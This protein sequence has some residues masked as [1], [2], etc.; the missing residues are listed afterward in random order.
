MAGPGYEV[1]LHSDAAV[2]DA[3]PFGLG[4]ATPFQT[5]AWLAQWYASFCAQPDH[6]P[7]IALVLDPADPRAPMTERLVMAMPLVR[8]RRHGLPLIEWADRGVTDCNLPL[9]GS[10]P[11][12]DIDAAL[13]AVSRAVR[14]YAR[15]AMRKMPRTVDGRDNPLAGEARARREEIDAFHLPL[16]AD[17]KAFEARLGA[18]KVRVLR[19]AKRILA[20]TGHEPVFRF[21]RSVAERRAVLDLIARSQSAR[22]GGTEGYLLDDP[23]YAGF[24][25]ALVAGDAVE[26]GVTRL[27]AIWLGDRPVAGLLTLVAHGR[28]VCVRLGMVDDAEIEKAGPGRLLVFEMA[29]WAAG[30]GFGVLDLS[31]GA[32]TLKTWLHCEAQPLVKVTRFANGFA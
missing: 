26:G 3:L 32:N 15:L 14:P 12:A 28:C 5:R 16:G 10:R 9:F 6:A 20:E 22:H 13:D 2:L 23:I 24:Y 1:A 21:A 4:P 18:K 27:A 8:R 7:L 25:E 17:R 30:Q 11:L 31:L 19:R 29:G